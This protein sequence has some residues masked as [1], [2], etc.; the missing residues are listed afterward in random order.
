LKTLKKLLRLIAY[1]LLALI[2]AIALF[3]LCDAVLGR[4]PVN[5]EP[6]GGHDVLIYLQS[7]GTHSDLALP[8]K[9][10]V[11]DWSHEILYAHTRSQDSNM[12]YLSFGWGEKTF[13]LE[14]P[15][16]EDLTVKNALRASL[17][18]GSPAVH[19]RYHPS[20]QASENSIPIH[21]SWDQYRRLVAYLQ[22][23]LARSEQSQLIH[24]PTPDDYGPS[25]A[26]YEGNGHYGLNH[27]C[28]TWINRALKSCG[29]KAAV[30]TAFE[31]GVMRWY[32]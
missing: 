9:T 18:F 16:W 22:K 13:Y 31:P 20:L 28:N 1:G 29:Q 11:I 26:F 17:G 27:S 5:E 23:S 4:I 19:T 2:I 10:P 30:W 21:L 12:T 7:D 14:T 15:N 8:I 32:Q 6:N 25:D 3:F 24:I